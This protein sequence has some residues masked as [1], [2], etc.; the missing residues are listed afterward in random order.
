MTTTNN[1]TIK[2]FGKIYVSKEK[3]L[4]EIVWLRA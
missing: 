3:V 4:V 1:T 2:L